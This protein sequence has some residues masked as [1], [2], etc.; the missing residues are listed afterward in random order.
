MTDPDT[1]VAIASPPGRGGLGILRVSGPHTSSV[2]RAL[3]GDLPAA[4]RAV[5]RTFHDAD[6]SAIDRGL[7][8]YFEAPHSFTGEHCLELHAHGS[9]VVLDL[10]LARICALGARTARPGEFSQRAFLNGKMDLAQAEAVA[11]LIAS[12]SVQAARAATRSLE[13]EFSRE[14]RALQ[15][16]M[17]AARVHVEAALDFPEEEIDF[18]SDGALADRLDALNQQLTGILSRAGQGILLREGA[19]V[20]I[21]GLPNVGKSSLINA[22]S[23]RDVAIVTPIPGTTRDALR[24][25]IDLEGLPLHIVDTAGLR[26][27]EDVVEAEGVR[28]TRNEIERADLVIL[29]F[30]DTQDETAEDRSVA[31]LLPQPL[32]F[33]AVR[34][35]VDLSGSAPGEREDAVYLSAK[36]GQG[37]DALRQALIRRLRYTPQDEGV[38]LARRRHLI[39][40]ESARSFLQ[41][42]R[43]NLQDT[44]AGEIVAEDLRAA[45]RAL[46]EI[47]GVFTT[48]DLL[49][50]I[51]ADFCIGK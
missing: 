46:G 45:H 29:V 13:G 41:Q 2:A 51:F 21:A 15:E 18:L 37:M 35:K 31:S 23:G 8:L 44:R 12:G 17:I 26:D 6:G 27:T 9:P 10:L 28:R 4:R 24:E 3:L 42:A 5:L 30:D 40:L 48:D 49:G 22:L 7:A 11:D 39:A 50:R 33:L 14:I 43:A 16:G 25:T 38:F 36:T 20:V 1:I 47:L 32:P 19:R 34:N